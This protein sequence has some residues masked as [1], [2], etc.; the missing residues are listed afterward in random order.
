[1]EIN[2]ESNR[3]R[4]RPEWLLPFLYEVVAYHEAVFG[5]IPLQTLR[6]R[7]GKGRYSGY[8]APTLGIINLCLPDEINAKH[9]AWLFSHELL[10]IQG[11]EHP[12]Y[13]AALM[14]MYHPVNQHLWR[15]TGD[16]DT[17]EAV[18]PKRRRTCKT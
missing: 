18:K 11:V 16:K 13:G 3:S 9:V 5:P 14:D 17:A 2:L 15:W 7:I 8:A 1:M 12:R 10:H 4:V 6:L